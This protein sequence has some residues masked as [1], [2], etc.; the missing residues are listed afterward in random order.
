MCVIAVEGPPVTFEQWEAGK[1]FP[2]TYKS[3][4][5]ELPQ[6]VH[7]MSCGC[8]KRSN[9][10][11]GK[12]QFKVTIDRDGVVTHTATIH[13]S[14]HRDTGNERRRENG[15]MRRVGTVM[16]MNKSTLR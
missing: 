1:S 12:M 7:V 10:R 13:L 14:T 6:C 8:D 15:C 4:H 16:L 2:K 11:S 5:V 3:H 9:T